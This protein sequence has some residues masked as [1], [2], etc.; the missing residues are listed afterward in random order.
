MEPFLYLAGLHIRFNLLKGDECVL[1]RIRRSN[2]TTVTF[3]VVRIVWSSTSLSTPQQFRSDDLVPDSIHNA[4]QCVQCRKLLIFVK[5]ISNI[6]MFYGVMTLWLG[7]TS[8]YKNSKHF[9]FFLV[10]GGQFV[11]SYV[12]QEAGKYL[13]FQNNF[14]NNL[15]SKWTTVN[16]SWHILSY[17][18]LEFP[19]M[20]NIFSTLYFIFLF[21]D[22]SMWNKDGLQSDF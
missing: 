20:I 1:R 13:P 14:Q 8:T 11:S 12:R 19:S 10:V 18:F 9:F 2:A 22:K 21:D 17:K 16:L 4:S 15:T 6:K 3:V 5:E 7:Q